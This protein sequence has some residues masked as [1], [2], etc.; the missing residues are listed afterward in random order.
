MCLCDVLAGVSDEYHCINTKTESS[1]VRR[2]YRVVLVLQC[3]LMFACLCS[4]LLPSTLSPLGCGFDSRQRGHSCG[5]GS[6]LY[7]QTGARRHKEN[8]PGKVPDQHGR[9]VGESHKWFFF[10]RCITVTSPS[11]AVQLSFIWSTLI[12]F[13]FHSEIDINSPLL[14]REEIKV[15]ITR[16]E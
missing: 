10:S 8:K 7:P 2:R 14:L 4:S 11:K 9:I 1:K 15:V 12:L 5:A 13:R 6:P 16:N 3:E